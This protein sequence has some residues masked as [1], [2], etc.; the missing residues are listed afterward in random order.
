MKPARTARSTAADSGL[1][2][3][4]LLLD[5]ERR[6]RMALRILRNERLLADL[7]DH[8]LIQNSMN[9]PGQNIAWESYARQDGSGR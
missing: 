8:F 5:R 1:Y 3:D 4:F 6:R 2:R 9:E 7:Y